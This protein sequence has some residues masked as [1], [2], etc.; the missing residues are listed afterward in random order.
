MPSLCRYSFPHT[1][2]IAYYTHPRTGRRNNVFDDR[3]A[4]AA[5]LCEY[6]AFSQSGCTTHYVRTSFRLFMHSREAGLSEQM[7]E[8]YK[9]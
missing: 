7:L 2:D 6:P 1:G 9:V 4:A 3:D 5:K 8:W